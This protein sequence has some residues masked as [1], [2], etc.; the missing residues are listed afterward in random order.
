MAREVQHF[1]F[2]KKRPSLGHAKSNG[3]AAA[4]SAEIHTALVSAL[5]EILVGTGGWSLKDTTQSTPRCTDDVSPHKRKNKKRSA[6][7]HLPS[8][9]VG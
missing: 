1:P 4:I 8:Q 2:H 7:P 9:I 3:D 5:P 6:L